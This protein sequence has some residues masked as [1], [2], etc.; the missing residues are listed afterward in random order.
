MSQ[1]WR[2]LAQKTSAVGLVSTFVI[3][4]GSLLALPAPAQAAATKQFNYTCSSGPFSN[5]SISVGLSAPDSVTV[6][7]GFDLTV[8]IPSLT[9]ATHPTSATT[10]QANLDMT[11]TGGTAATGVKTG[12]QITTTQTS[13][14]ASSVTYRIT[15]TAGTT[16]KV[17]V[18]PGDLKLAFASN[19]SSVT[20]CRPP[21][22]TTDVLDVPIGTG[23]GNGTNTDV[24]EYKCVGPATTDTQDVEIKVEM[25]MPTSARVGQQFAIKWKGTYTA[26][27]ELKAPTTGQ[28]ITAKV[29]AYASLTGISGLTSATGEGSTGTITAGQI[30]TLPTTQIDLKSTANA[31]GTATVKPAKVNFGSDTATGNQ[32]KI[33][34]TVQNESELK[35]YT[36]AVGNASTSPTPS[37][38][39]TPSNTSPRPTRTATHTVTVTPTQKKSQTP[40]AGADTG[41]G[42]EMGPDGRLFI[43]TGTALIVAAAAGGLIM[44]RR[45]IRG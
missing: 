7:Q 35:T 11:V 18:K 43:V 19:V 1:A 20:T 13:V 24:V 5:T 28:T 42:G 9:I 34:C 25:T 16:T 26:G 17:S 31:A 15:V 44:R 33:E 29:F 36:F 12:P 37:P 22:S 10:L 8:N 32:P 38:S 21:T 23:S 3:F 27:K 45:T 14:T 4:A 30:V 41:G 40:K 2:R 6:G 39:P